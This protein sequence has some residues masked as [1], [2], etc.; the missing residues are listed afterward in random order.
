MGIYTFTSRCVLDEFENKAK[1][2]QGY[3]TVSH[4]NVIHFDCHTEGV[5]HAR[6]RDEWESAALQN[7]NTKCNGLLP[8]WGPMVS[9]SSFATCLA[10]HN[11]YLQECTGFREPTFHSSV[12]DIRLM[13]MRFAQQRS[14]S[15]ETGGGG[16]VS[17]MFL[18]PYMVQTALYVL[19]TTRQSLGEE[20]LIKTF[21]DVSVDSWITSCYEVNGPLFSSVLNIFVSPLSRWLTQRTYFLKRLLL[22]AHVRKISGVPMN[23]LLNTEAKDYQVYKPVLMFFS[24]V[25]QLHLLCKSKLSKCDDWQ[26]Q[27]SIYLRNNDDA[28]LKAAEKLLKRFEED[29]M[30][31]ESFGEFCDVEGLLEEIPDPDQFLKDVLSPYCIDGAEVFC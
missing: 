17:N 26:Q 19:N 14:F 8:M 24:L 23:T 12:H 21:C 20:Q 7:A 27:M 6:S 25:N 5:R 11:N 3:C 4:F 13:L 28:N 9:E 10:R 15:K 29:V 18:L 31:C 16:K 1:R 22:L 30:P 2:T